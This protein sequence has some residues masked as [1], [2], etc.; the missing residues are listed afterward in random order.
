MREKSEDS[1]KVM[2]LFVSGWLSD[3]REG[4]MEFI[5]FDSRISRRGAISITARV[6]CVAAIVSKQDR[7]IHRGD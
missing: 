1:Y 3:K 4:L 6:V 2:R 7:Y 5:G